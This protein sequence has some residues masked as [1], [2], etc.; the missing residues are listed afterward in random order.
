MAKRKKR[1]SKPANPAGGTPPARLAREILLTA[2]DLPVQQILQMVVQQVDDA[3]RVLAEL[4]AYDHDNVAAERAGLLLFTGLRETPPPE[5]IKRQLRKDIK[6]VLERALPDKSIPDDRKMLLT[7]IY[8]LSGGSFSAEQYSEFFKDF[9]AAARRMVG[10]VEARL[11]DE[12][13]ELEDALSGMEIIGLENVIPDPSDI[14]YVA[15]TGSAFA[16]KNPAGSAALICAAAAIGIEV[17]A[18]PRHIVPHLEAFADQRSDRAAWYLAELSRWPA[19]GPIGEKA[20]QIAQ[21]MIS[22]GLI[23]RCPVDRAYSHGFMSMIDG[24]GSRNLTLFFRTPEGGMDALALIINDTVGLKDAW[25]AF[26]DSAGLEE[27]I[28]ERENGLEYAQISLPFAR[29]IIAD[30]WALHESLDKPLFGRFFIYRNYLGDEPIRPRRREPNLGWYMMEMMVPTPALAR[31]SGE[32]VDHGPFGGLSFSGD[33]AYEFVR[34]RMPRRG[35]RLKKPDFEAF[36]RDIVPEER[37]RLL[38][39][40]AANLELEA[41]AGRATS[42]INQL[43]ARTYA[44]LKLGVMPFHEVPYVRELGRCAA[45]RIIENVKAG[46]ANQQEANEAGLAIDAQMDRLIQQLQGGWTGEL[47]EE[48]ED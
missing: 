18:E 30:A 11:S 42:E 15:R 46:F 28:Y 16:A 39:R 34:Q 40:M 10:Q 2:P 8:G 44:A 1:I 37:E 3:G 6:P 32:L 43:A 48:D 27:A 35:S 9:D 12:A 26:D 33:A 41:L 38:E 4:A 13:S 21:R 20:G 29:E 47:D 14:E 17:G 45:E 7:A 22:T 5:R 36:L 23:P 25:M 24:S 19:S 31:D